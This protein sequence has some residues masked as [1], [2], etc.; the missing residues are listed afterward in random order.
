MQIFVTGLAAQAER[1]CVPLELIMVEWNPPPE[2]PGLAEAL[3][4]PST[5][6]VVSRIIQ[7]PAE[8]HRQYKHSEGLPLY[9]MIAKNV[10]IRRSRGEFVLA[11][12]IDLLFS[13]ELF[14]FL[15]DR[16]LI[17]G[18]MYRVDR[19]D[20]DENVPLE[21]TI[22]EQLAYCATHLLRINGR[23]ESFPVTATGERIVDPA[24]INVADP[25]ELA[26]PLVS[27]ARRSTI[28]AQDTAD[29][30]NSAAVDPR[31]AKKKGPEQAKE[32]N[33]LSTKEDSVA[34]L[35][36]FYQLERGYDETY[37]WASSVVAV[38][39]KAKRPGRELYLDVDPTAELGPVALHF[40]IDKWGAVAT[41]DRRSIVKLRANFPVGGS[42]RIEIRITNADERKRL[43]VDPRDLGYRVYSIGCNTAFSA[44]SEVDRGLSVSVTPRHAAGVLE[45]I[46][47]LWNLW[48]SGTPGVRLTLPVPHALMSRLR[49]RFDNDGL[50]LA[51]TEVTD[52][53]I[54]SSQTPHWDNDADS[55]QPT[56]TNEEEAPA[57]VEA[58]ETG[59]SDGR[60]DE[61]V[62]LPE[63]DEVRSG[64]DYLHTNACGDFTLMSRED[65]CDLRGYPEWDMYSINIDSALCISA[66]R[67]GIEEHFLTARV[68]HI[69]HEV[70]SGYSPEGQQVLWERLRKKGIDWLEFQEIY[71]WDRQ[72]R[73]LGSTMIF[74]RRDWGLIRH[75]LPDETVSGAGVETEA[76]LASQ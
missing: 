25:A 35:S 71:D 55:V 58:N 34:L 36:G 37:R 30:K 47:R 31:N 21:A 46:Q 62:P 17:T 68:C 11:T 64:A 61:A 6:W 56:E 52:E 43:S 28:D 50:S 33:Q 40:R 74:N 9:Q 1:F 29:L 18:K 27:P 53:Q 76:P 72:L 42:A 14:E 73:R 59:Q 63:T 51:I 22:N 57:A 60:S 12:N 44:N 10:G 65:W 66:A 38:D 49:P 5:E 70:G 32:A 39:V 26:G 16:R 8:L 41:I 23:G 13:D 75:K 69:E 3:T 19:W 67:A 2:K 20:A 7:V 4:W 45:R 24:D 15:A 54:D 48:R